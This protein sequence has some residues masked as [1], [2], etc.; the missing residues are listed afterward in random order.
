MNRPDSNNTAVFVDYENIFY[1]IRNYYSHLPDAAPYTAEF[2]RA[3]KQ[4][5]EKEQVMQVIVTNA[6][7]DFERMGSGNL[8]TL[9]LMGIHAQNVLGTAHKNA[10][11][12]QMCIDI[13]QLVYT[14]QDIRSFVIMA[15]DRDYIPVVQ[16]L[17]RLGKDIHVAAF[18]NTLSGDLLEVIG[19]KNFIDIQGMIT[20]PEA[21]RTAP[22][23]ALVQTN[24]FPEDT[25]AASQPENP[26]KIVGQI[27]LDN[28]RKR[29]PVSR[30]QRVTVQNEVDD[31]TACLVHILNFIGK[32]KSFEPGVVQVLRHLTEQMPQLANW[33]R[34]ELLEK[35]QLADI[36][37]IITKSGSGEYDY[38]AVVVNYD[39]DLVRKLLAT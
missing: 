5:L 15:G 4:H 25:T 28:T 39:H 37:K 12:M 26:L 22:A 2:I 33:Q 7:A 14:R 31:A 10:A 32:R 8:G 35:L 30:G 21:P 3:L 13:M 18:R 23:P 38:A 16:H 20:L 27:N 11:D 36:I 19:E 9:Y 24:M 6:Y 34:K 1:Y 17:K 29:I